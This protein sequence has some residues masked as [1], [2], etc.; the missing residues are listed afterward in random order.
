M[1]GSF[2]A[3]VEHLL[4]PLVRHPVPEQ[5]G[6]RTNENGLSK[7]LRQ[8]VVEAVLVERRRKAEGVGRVSGD[9]VLAG[10]GQAFLQVHHVLVS[11]STGRTVAA[12]EAVRGRSGIAI[13]AIVV[14]ASDWRPCRIA[15]FYFRLYQRN[16]SSK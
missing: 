6:H 8:R 5:V 14:A 13:R 3:G 2:L 11:L 10:D 1:S 12:F 16:P 7:P 15:P 4:D 9:T